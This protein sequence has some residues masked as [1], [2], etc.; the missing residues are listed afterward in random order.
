[1]KA[2]KRYTR[3]TALSSNVRYRTEQT[4]T[5]AYPRYLPTE[6][7]SLAGKNAAPEGF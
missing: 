7:L 3:G 1:M 6:G 4:R 2:R 5:K